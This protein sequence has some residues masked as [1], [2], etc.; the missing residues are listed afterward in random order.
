MLVSYLTADEVDVVRFIYGGVVC[1][2]K[3]DTANYVDNTVKMWL[4]EPLGASSVTLSFTNFI[5]EDYYDYVEV[6]QDDNISAT[7]HELLA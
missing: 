2:G 1:I 7:V 4:I 6:F 5:V 3:D